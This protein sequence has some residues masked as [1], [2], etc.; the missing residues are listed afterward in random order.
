MIGNVDRVARREHG[1]LRDLHR[2]GEARV[3]V[4]VGI[5]GIDHAHRS[6]GGRQ[7]EWSG[8]E[9]GQLI[10][11]EEGEAAP[12]RDDDADIL[13]QVVM[14]GDPDAIADPGPGG[15]MR[16]EVDAVLRFEPGKELGDQLRLN[17]HG[18]RPGFVTIAQQPVEEGSE[19]GDTA[20]EIQRA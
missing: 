2:I 11:R 8:I 1:G 15:N 3:K 10:R 4:E 20:L 17:S 13:L 5:V 6:S 19:I 7:F 9:V 14:R 16:N 12:A 18:E